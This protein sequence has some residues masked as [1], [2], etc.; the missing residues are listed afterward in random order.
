MNSDLKIANGHFHKFLNIL[1]SNFNIPFTSKDSLNF[2][3]AQLIYNKCLELEWSSEYFFKH[4]GNFLIK[5]KYPN[6]TVADFF[7]IEIPKLKTHQDYQKLLQEQGE[8]INSRERILFKTEKSY[9]WEFKDNLNSMQISQLNALYPIVDKSKLDYK[10]E[11]KHKTKV[12][13][14][15]EAKESILKGEGTFVNL[16]ENQK[17]KL[18][19][20][21]DELNKSYNASE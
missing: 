10:P 11:V 3:K 13:I 1:S 20:M 2:L 12:M 4:L 8:S 16:S 14:F 18:I 5:Q 19:K 17:L 7:D 6:F 21:L 15:K 9:L